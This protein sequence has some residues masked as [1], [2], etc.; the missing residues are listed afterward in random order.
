MIAHQE[1]L[2]SIKTAAKL[3][4]KKK[5]L[6]SHDVLFL[7][8]VQGAFLAGEVDIPT[9]LID[10]GAA[11][12]QTS[13]KSFYNNQ[14]SPVV[15][16]ASED[17]KNQILSEFKCAFENP[18]VVIS[19]S[20]YKASVLKNYFNIDSRII[21][22]PIRRNLF[23]P[24]DTDGDYF[25]WS[26]RLIPFSRI[27]VLLKTFT[28]LDETIYITGDG[29]ERQKS[30][31]KYY[32]N[33]NDNIHYLGYV[34]QNEFVELLSGA[35]AVIHTKEKDEFPYIVREAHAVGTPAIA[36]DYGGVP[37]IMNSELGIL[38][39]NSAQS[40]TRAVESFDQ[41]DYDEHALRKSTRKYDPE[42]VL[43]KYEQAG[44]DA[45]DKY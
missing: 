32:A 15:E 36:S 11:A 26:Q 25:I 9:V 10:H 2:V 6:Q 39:S 27:D 45:I 24:K 34:E 44:K 31:V 16:W 17:N 1:E 22:S 13:L 21:H 14:V 5:E 23:T 33:D 8:G 40:L 7:V 20:E 35:K 37:I 18:D 12:T 41:D 19:D 3:A 28:E 42:I 29:K 43:P 38:H 4:G 30:I